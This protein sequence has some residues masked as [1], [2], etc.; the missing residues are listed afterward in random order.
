VIDNEAPRPDLR[1][2][3]VANGD[4]STDDGARLQDAIATTI[5]AYPNAPPAGDLVP[6]PKRSG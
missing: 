4:F 3:F 1:F 5:G 6:E 2:A